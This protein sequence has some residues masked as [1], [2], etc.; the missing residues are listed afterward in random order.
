VPDMLIVTALELRH[1]VATLVQMKA[2]D[3]LRTHG[4]R[5]RTASHPI[6]CLTK[7]ALIAFAISSGLWSGNA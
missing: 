5:R 1:P 4:G 7:N 3:A 6:G 2:G